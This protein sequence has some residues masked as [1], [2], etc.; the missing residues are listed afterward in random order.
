MTATS[1]EIDPAGV[2]AFAGELMPI[3]KGAL[4]SHMIDLGDRTGLFA[5]AAQGPATSQELADRAGLHERYV[6]EWLG[7]MATV[8]IVEL[9]PDRAT[10]PE[11]T[12]VLPPEHA[13]LLVGPMSM[14]PVAG[15]NTLLGRYVPE[16]ARVFR[17]GGGIPYEAYR[18]DFTEAM[19]AIGRGGYDAFLVDAYL[20]MA[21]GLRETLSAGATAA[22]VACG[23][24]HA[25]VVL[26]AA[27][28]ASTFT[29]YDLDD[30][31][32]AHGRAEAAAAGLTNVR[33]EVA[34]VAA[35]TVDE[36]FDAVF[37][38]DA[39]HDQVDPAE[40]LRR[41]HAALAP[42]GTFL[43]REPHVADRIADNLDNP[44]A[45][46]VYSVSTLHCLTVSLAHGGAGIGTA[47]GEQL[48]RRMLADAGFADPTMHQPPAEP[49]DVVYVT[50]PVAA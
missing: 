28:P 44:M 39:L 1:T 17:E 47:F 27:F 7:A 35:L 2:E 46:I 48:A 49:F 16:I 8:G 24:G 13:A 33:F 23:S 9:V 6:R 20:P 18:P 19:D 50:H 32:I 25:L 41:V 38:F 15:M 4:I 22:D 14:A 37:M 11:P 5:A 36:P 3:L 21:P 45:P 40:V 34:D 43:L 12:F 30:E 26:A 42:T 29:G 10:E 31:A